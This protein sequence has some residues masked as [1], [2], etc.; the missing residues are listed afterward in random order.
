MKYLLA[1]LLVLAPIT[2]KAEVF[3]RLLIPTTGLEPITKENILMVV[4]NVRISNNLWPVW[5]NPLLSKAAQARAEDMATNSYF[6]HNDWL[7]K[8]TDSGYKYCS[9]GENLAQG[10]K[11][12]LD[13]EDT[14]FYSPG[15]K[16]N[17]LSPV[18]KETGIGIA[19]GKLNGKKVYFVVQEFGNPQDN[20]K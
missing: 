13:I 10:F 16:A 12:A 1:I 19:E 8:I 11:Y 9:A 14:W 20:C 6:S 7:K 2:V 18:Y 4:N 5:E 17:M 15:H 3:N